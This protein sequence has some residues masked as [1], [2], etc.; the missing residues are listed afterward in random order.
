MK[1]LGTSGLDAPIL[2]QG[3]NQTRRGSH[4]RPTRQGWG[5]RAGTLASFHSI[6]SSARASRVGGVSMPSAFALPLTDLRET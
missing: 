2:T 6:T 5:R 4:K 1:R 3:A